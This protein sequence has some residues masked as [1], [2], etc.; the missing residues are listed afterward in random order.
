MKSVTAPFLSNYER[1]GHMQDRAILHCDCNNFFASVELLSRPDLRDRPVAVTGDPENRHGIILAKNEIAKRAGVKTAETIWQAKKKCPGLICL[2][3]HHRLYYDFSRRINRIYLDYTDLIDP[4]SVDESFLDIT[5]SLK[6]L[7]KTPAE[8]AD[9]LRSRVR[10]EIGITI[11]V[12]VSFCKVFAKLGS[13]YKKPDATTVI[14]R[15]NLSSIV[16]PLPASELLFV[17]KK[18]NELL[19]RIGIRTIGD[20]AHADREDL[21]RVL[22]IQGDTLWK[23]ANGLDDEPVSPYYVKHDP[24]SVGNGMTFKRDIVGREEIQI[25]IGELSDEVSTRLRAL[26]KKGYVVALQIKTPNFKVIQKQK[27]LDAPTWLQSRISEVAMELFGSV[28]AFTLPVRSLTVTVSDLTQAGSEKH[29]M[30][31][32]DEEETPQIQKQESIE[33]AMNDIRQ[34]YGHGSIHLGLHEKK[35]IG[36]EH[37]KSDISGDPQNRKNKEKH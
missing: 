25:G 14:T 29:Q 35:E 12:G 17:G 22:G 1:G 23:Y 7:K 26:N 4:F 19:N 5:G 30:N 13:D 37:R 11:S 36:I 34:K 2:P 3:S 20:I 15:D 32:F 28:Y 8:V 10:K 33:A 16:Y 27:R 31:I 21:M 24:K 6:M 18:T 9:E